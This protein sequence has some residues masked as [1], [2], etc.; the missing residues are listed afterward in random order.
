MIVLRSFLFHLFFYVG[1]LTMSFVLLPLLILPRPL[2]IPQLFTGY[3]TWLLYYVVG[4]SFRI[5]GQEHI[6]QH[7]SFLI[8]SNHQSAW[9]TLIFFQIF[10]RPVMILKKELLSIPL[11]GWFLQRTGMLALDR[12]HPAKSFRSLIKNIEVQINKEKRPVCIFPE[13]TR[14]PPGMPGP[15]QRGVYLIHKHLK[16]EILCVAHNAGLF[17][18]PHRFIIRPGVITV[19]IYPPLPSVLDTAPLEEILPRMIHAKVNELSKKGF[20]DE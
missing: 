15:F 5:E 3:A 12:K 18:Q 2:F 11:F 8:V 9:E 6:P 17:W 20:Y 14:K 10:K 7:G 4:L 13:G 16:P 19:F 1:T